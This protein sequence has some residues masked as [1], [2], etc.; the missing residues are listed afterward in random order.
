MAT[1]VVGWGG[2]RNQVKAYGCTAVCAVLFL[3]PVVVMCTSRR[4]WLT[5]VVTMTEPAFHLYGEPK[6][7]T[8]SAKVEV[9]WKP[10]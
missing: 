1:A 2:W 5:L 6:A 10:D 3:H 9:E 7:S 8:D 4:W